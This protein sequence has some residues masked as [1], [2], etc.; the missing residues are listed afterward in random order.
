[1]RIFNPHSFSMEY[2]I[3]LAGTPFDDGAIDLD[4]LELLAQYLHDIAKGALQMRMLGTSANRGRDTKQLAR[5]LN[6][7]LRGLSTGSTVLHLECRPFRETLSGVQ[8]NLFH[9]EIIQRLPDQTPMSLIMESFQDALDPESSG[10]MLDKNLLQH[11]QNFKKVFFNETQ[12]LQLSNRGSQPEIE[13]RLQDFKRFKQIE[14]KIPQPQLVVISGQVEE[15]KYSKAKVTFIPNKG[16]AFTGFL[17]ENVSPAE[18]AG[19]WGQKAT[20]RGIAYFKPN[21]TMAYVEIDKVTL[22]KDS[23]VYFSQSP[24][25][26]TT[27]QQIDRQMQAGKGRI[28]ALQSLVEAFADESWDTSLEE[29]IKFLQE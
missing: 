15:L 23:D 28:N 4:R 10:E 18:M 24:I 14:D 20:I 12:T 21:G 11:L 26:E 5:A 27:Q 13:L 3:K 22:A 1:L 7:R 8:G 25:Q 17:G 6:I 2:D 19:F 9:Q 16:R 29:D